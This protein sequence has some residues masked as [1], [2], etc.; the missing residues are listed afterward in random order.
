MR[1]L[2]TL[3][4]CGQGRREEVRAGGGGTPKIGA[5]NPKKPKSEPKIEEQKKKKRFH[6]AQNSEEDSK[7]FWLSSLSF[8][9]TLSDIPW[10]TL[11]ALHAILNRG[12]EQKI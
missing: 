9:S 5:Y 2:E 8:R 1:S 4:V 12:F 10:T 7:L 3:A 6:S 11:T